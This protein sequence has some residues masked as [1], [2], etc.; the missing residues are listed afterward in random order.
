MTLEVEG[1]K[2]KIIKLR[3]SF[4]ELRL[5]KSN[6][7]NSEGKNKNSSSQPFMSETLN[8]QSQGTKYLSEATQTLKRIVGIGEMTNQELHGQ[9]GKI[10]KTSKQLDD[11][12]SNLTRSQKVIRGMQNRVLTNKIVLVAII[13]VLALLIIFLIYFRLKNLFGRVVGIGNI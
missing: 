3:T 11:S 7:K 9:T 6:G 1:Y 5:D 10:E 4:T 12:E 13:I 2:Q 8:L